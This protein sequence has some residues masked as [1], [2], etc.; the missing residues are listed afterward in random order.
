MS[1]RVS[2]DYELAWGTYE[3]VAPEYLDL[4]VRNANRAASQIFAVNERHGI[5]VD[6]A[7]VGAAIEDSSLGE[8]VTVAGDLG[9]PV[10]QLTAMLSRFDRD[11]VRALTS[12]PDSFLTALAGSTTQRSANHTYTHRYATGL[13]EADISADVA[14]TEAVLRVRGL[15]NSGLVVAPKNIVTPEFDRA[16]LA[17]G[18]D[19]IRVAPRSVL[20]RSPPPSGRL[21]GPGIRIGRFVDAFLPVTEALEKALGTEPDLHTPSTVGNVFFRPYLQPAALRLHLRHVRRVARRLAASGRDVH[22]WSHP[23]NFGRDVDGAL[24]AYETCIADVTSIVSEHA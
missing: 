17:L 23:H 3:K 5:Q 4:N 10:A 13:T 8:R 12:I 24:A 22:L 2:M 20:Y 7:L 9:A 19:A 21:A 11:S 6:W 18:V 1:L 15:G 14:A 16:C